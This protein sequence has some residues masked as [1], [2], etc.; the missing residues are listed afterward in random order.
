VSGCADYSALAYVLAGLGR[1]RFDAPE[2]P[3]LV[4]LDQCEIPLQL[5]RWYAEKLALP[6][7]TV[8]TVQADILDYKPV[9][10]FDLIVTSSFVGYF[11]PP[12]RAR[13][14]AQYAALL[15]PAGRLVFSNRL[16][17][18]PEDKPIGF[19]VSE[20]QAFLVRARQANAAL[21]LQDQ[22]SDAQLTQSVKA[23]CQHFKSYPVTSEASLM[24]SLTQ[25]GLQA[26][27]CQSVRARPLQSNGLQK[28]AGPS[29][30]DG[31]T[32]VLVEA[33]KT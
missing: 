30:A 11:D 29:L 3:Q 31:S 5:S 2:P 18:L 9:L 14:F 24:A 8:K 13:L 12:A 23:Y 16:R 15:A 26:F 19:S 22:L 17:D 33:G 21:A 25:A 7:Q 6:V 32:Y 27:S 28:L 4:L 1:D 20:A 10:A